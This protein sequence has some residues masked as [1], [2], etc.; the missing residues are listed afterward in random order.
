[1]K[2]NKVTN[3]DS[4]RIQKIWKKDIIVTWSPLNMR[5][6]VPRLIGYYE[7]LTN[8]ASPPKLFN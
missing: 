6:E 7:K 5:T 3:V 4:L 8:R 2:E 1:M